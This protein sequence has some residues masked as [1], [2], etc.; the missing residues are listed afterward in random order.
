MKATGGVTMLDDTHAH[1]VSCNTT[2]K[3]TLPL[4]RYKYVL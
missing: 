1:A 2:A 4:I 3:L